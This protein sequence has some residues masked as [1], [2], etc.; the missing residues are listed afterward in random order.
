MTEKNAF[1][2]TYGTM[3]NPPD[4]LHTQFEA[5]VTALKAK[6]GQEYGMLINGKEHFSEEKFEDTSPIDTSTI[7]GVFQKGTATDGQRRLGCGQSR[8]PGL[9]PHEMARPITVSAKRRPDLD[10]RIF[11]FGAVIAMEVGKNRMEA[12]ADAA[13]TADLIR[14]ACDQMEENNGFVVKMGTDPLVGYHLHELF[15]RCALTGSG[16]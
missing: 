3:Y 1:R 8:L 14:Y 12:L 10:E 6:L 13:E 2:L 16:W 5:A 9:G 15:G 7:L 11:D 4:E